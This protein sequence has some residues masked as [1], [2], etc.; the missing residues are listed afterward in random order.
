MSL[1]PYKLEA[2][3][4]RRRLEAIFE[5]KGIPN[6]QKF[7]CTIKGTIFVRKQIHFR[8]WEDGV[9]N[10]DSVNNCFNKSY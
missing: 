6:D 8:T 9:Q 3:V 5:T 10:L 1:N 4:Q 7:V 2:V